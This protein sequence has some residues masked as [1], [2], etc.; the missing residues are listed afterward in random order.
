M[1]PAALSVGEDM[2]MY[3]VAQRNFLHANFK[4][5]APRHSHFSP[6]FEIAIHS[7]LNSF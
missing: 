4:K 1:V 2:Q 6:F 7:N 5:N 3:I